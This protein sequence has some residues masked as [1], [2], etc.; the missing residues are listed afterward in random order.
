MDERRCLPQG[1]EICHRNGIPLLFARPVKPDPGAPA[2]QPHRR[3]GAPI[4]GSA[5]DGRRRPAALGTLYRMA[6][7]RRR[8]NYI[9]PNS[10]DGMPVVVD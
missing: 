7:A 5:L 9:L 6:G 1:I 2:D 10:A 4:Q 3:P 8:A